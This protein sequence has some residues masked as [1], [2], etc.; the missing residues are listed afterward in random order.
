MASFVST[1]F[2]SSTSSTSSYYTTPPSHSFHEVN[3]EHENEVNS[4]HENMDEVL[5]DMNFDD[6]VF[7]KSSDVSLQDSSVTGKKRKFS[8]ESDT[9][10][11]TDSDCE[12]RSKLQKVVEGSIS[13]SAHNSPEKKVNPIFKDPMQISPE[14]APSRLVL[15]VGSS[16]KRPLHQLVPQANFLEIKAEE[17]EKLAVRDEILAKQLPP[18][19]TIRQERME[20]CARYGDQSTDA[21]DTA[22]YLRG[23]IADIL[24]V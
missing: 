2:V 21:V 18:K 17:F 19:S 11:D 12:T 13:N 1:S 20:R 16:Y 9:D 3:D 4:D 23:M 15:R 10:S 24:D 7:F 6:R 5:S 8:S 14:K 22:E